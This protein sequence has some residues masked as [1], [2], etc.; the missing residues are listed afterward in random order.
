M[1]PRGRPDGRSLP[2]SAQPNPRALPLV[3][4]GD[5]PYRCSAPGCGYASS[6]SGALQR[7]SR[8]HSGQRPARCDFPGCSYAVSDFS[9]AR[10]L[11]SLPRCRVNLH[12]VSSPY[13][14]SAVII[15]AP[16]PR[17]A[18]SAPAAAQRD[19]TQ[20]PDLAQT[21]AQKPGTA[22]A[23]AH[24]G[25]AVQVRALPRLR[26]VAVLHPAVSHQAQA[27]PHPGLPLPSSGLHM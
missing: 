22:Q 20:R 9:C 14:R 10:P 19:L 1:R 3:D 25:E 11:C 5:K 16:G 6:D 7:H 27:H 15:W 21:L 24:Q 8:L 26:G 17:P 12:P 4:A 13:A 18:S 23:D 2:S